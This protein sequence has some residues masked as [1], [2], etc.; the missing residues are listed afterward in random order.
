MNSLNEAFE[1][2]VKDIYNAEKQIQKALPKV[3]KKCSD[4]QLKSSLEQHLEETKD[5]I[6]K[7][8]EMCKELGFKPTGEMCAGMQ[9]I[10]EENE[11][12]MSKGKVG[13]VMDAVIIAGAQKVEHYE[14]CGYGTAR[15]W[16]QQLGLNKSIIET[17]NGILEQESQTDEKLSKMAESTI[18]RQA[19]Q[20]GEGAES[21]TRNGKA[22]SEDKSPRGKASMR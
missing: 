22:K 7:L 19:M 11:E 18:N 13:P 16:A 2:L 15:A 1:S 5:Q 3:I 6:K 12:H 9:G 4:Q 17:I 21:N 20:A 8:E 10:I 14:I